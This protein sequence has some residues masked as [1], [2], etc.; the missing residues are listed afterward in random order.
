MNIIGCDLHTRYQVIAWRNEETGEVVTRRLE[1]ENGKARRFYASLPPGARVGIEATFPA[2]W[3]ERMLAE[4]SPVLWVGDAAG[5]RA[6]AVRAQKTDTRDAEHLLD[7]LL[8]K[9]FPRIWTPS[10][11]ERDLRQLLVHR[12]KLVRLRTAVKNQL[13]ALAIGQGVC[14]KGKL[15]SARGQAELK[16]LELMPWASRRRQELLGMLRQLD[17]SIG[18]LDGA[19][20]AA[21][22]GRPEVARLRTH[23]GVG[24]VT[25]LAFVLTIGPVGRF[26]NSRKLVSYLGLNPGEHSSGGRQRLGAISK[27]GNSMMRWL[28]VEAAPTAARFDPELRR[29]DQRLKFRRASGVAKVAI[30]RQLAVRWYWMLRNQTDYAHRVRMSGSPS[31]AVVDRGPSRN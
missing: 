12:N 8:T 27:Q 2:P 11:A 16:S 17:V 15:W 6:R 18:E 25:A 14:R 3:F 10:P 4:F 20:E 23:P 28:R 1:H 5:I 26:A 21:T 30:A 24:P 13:Q 31:S 22:P 19:V 29:D 9:R 7:L